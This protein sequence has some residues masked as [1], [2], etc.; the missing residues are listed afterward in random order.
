MPDA[1]LIAIAD[2]V[3]DVLDGASLSQSFTPTREERPR[4]NLE[5]LGTLKVTVVAVSKVKRRLTRGSQREATYVIDVGVQKKCDVD[6]PDVT[7]PLIYLVDEIGD[8]FLDAGILTGYTTATCLEAEH[9]EGASA[10]FAPEHYDNKRLFTGVVVL[11]FK[12]V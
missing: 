2:A 7:G 12:V 8:L 3:K 4:A 10:G 9:P 5:T 11:T 1:V 6:D